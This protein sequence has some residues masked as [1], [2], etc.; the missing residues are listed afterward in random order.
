MHL[1]TS[2]RTHTRG[3][4]IILAVA[5]L[6]TLG[7]V[8]CSRTKPRTSWWQF[9]RPRAQSVTLHNPGT[10][11]LPPPPSIFDP[12]TGTGVQP[13][14]PDLPP[15][16]TTIDPALMSENEPVRSPAGTVSELQ[17]VYFDFDS[18]NLSSQAQETLDRNVQWLL[19]NP[20]YDIQIGG[21]CDERGSVEYNFNLGQR[22]AK[23]VAAYLASRGVDPARLHTIS[24]GEEMP[25]A[26]GGSEAEFS[27]N[28]RVEF[29]VYY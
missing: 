4:W 18:D 15:P 27:Q 23:T 22:R 5:V 7:P 16:P 13:I 14:D 26:L 3:T 1:L 10:V 11:T 25:V 8:G 19:A 24:Y 29:M 12:E 2:R 21:H 17:T 9:W 20:N 28:R 6:L